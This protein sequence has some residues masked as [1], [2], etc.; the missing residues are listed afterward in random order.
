MN[1]FDPWHPANGHQISAWI[2]ERKRRTLGCPGLN[3][4]LLKRSLDRATIFL[5]YRRTDSPQACRVYDW[6]GQRFGYDSV[7]MDVAAIPVAVG[8]PDFIR[9]AIANSKVL[10]ALIGAGW[11]TKIHDAD[12][13]VRMEI[14]AAL[15]GHIPVLPVLIGNTPMP[16]AEELPASIS[17]I[18]SQN[19]ITVG[20]LHDFSTHMLTL[21]PKIEAILGALAPTSIATSDPRVIQRA[22][23]GIIHHLA[24]KFFENKA[25]PPADWKVVGT[26]YFSHGY[27]QLN[28]VTLFLHRV[29]RLAELV[30]LHFILSFWATDAGV[31]HILAGWVMSQLE[32]TPLIPDKRFAP[33]AKESEFD[34]KV[35]RSDEGNK[36]GIEAQLMPPVE[37]LAFPITVPGEIDLPEI[38]PEPLPQVISVL[39]SSK[40]YQEVADH[41]PDIEIIKT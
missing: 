10:I 6:L 28:E 25:M 39:R 37:K 11:L 16:D 5:S 31:E 18:A 33:D 27:R 26:D 17:T 9:Q 23:E 36:P 1:W 34:L 2:W 14:E 40:S 3:R 20:V 15:A 38:W 41:L 21:L 4:H 7:F 32:Q 24:G 22:C 8:F 30:E 12:D 13:P 29:A 35:R 19:A